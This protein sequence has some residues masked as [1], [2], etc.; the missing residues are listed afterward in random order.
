V[1]I[2]LQKLEHVLHSL[3]LVELAHCDVVGECLQLSIEGIK[4]TLLVRVGALKVHWLPI[5]AYEF[6]DQRRI[7]LW[8]ERGH[9]TADGLQ[10]RQVTRVESIVQF[11]QDFVEDDVE[12]VDAM[13]VD[14]GGGSINVSG[15]GQPR[16]NVLGT[17][18]HGFTAIGDNNG[19]IMGELLS[20]IVDLHEVLV[21][22]LHCPQL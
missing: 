9:K 12:E 8:K 13:P 3:K 17:L 11:V 14:N 21:V 19:I 20:L 22:T 5:Q 7:K 6:F 2:T 4:L 15:P 18:E 10:H 1:V 16:A